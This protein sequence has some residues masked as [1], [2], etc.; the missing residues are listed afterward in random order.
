MR[1]LVTGGAGFI[2]SHVVDGLIA[3]GYEVAVIDDLSTGVIGNVN[4]AAEFVE[5]DIRSDVALRFVADWKPDVL[6]HH[7]AQAN[8]VKSREDAATDAEINIVGSLRVLKAFM[9]AGGRRFVFAS[10]GAVYGDAAEIPTPWW[11]SA[12]PLSPYGITKATFEMYL[13]SAKCLDGLRPVCLRYG[14]VYGPRQRMDGE[15]GVVGL[16]ADAV[17]HGKPVAL[18]G[19]GLA[20]RDYVHVSDVVRANLI[21]CEE[22]CTG[23]I[24]IA[25]GIETS[26][27]RILALVEDAAG[28]EAATV[29]RAPLRP[30]EAKRVCLD[31]A[32]ASVVMGWVPQV[33]LSEGI[34]EV[35][36]WVRTLG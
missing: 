16:F 36:E 31:I 14:N 28:Q 19:D 10:S 23:W 29:R 18:Y 32:G 6:N 5:A 3:E 7:A 20:T 8:I 9:E 22:D 30:G 26:T 33:N 11:Y 24:N 21:A 27:E 4:S 1:V 13:W 2:A 25:T 15:S 12:N 34:K 17:L 35:V